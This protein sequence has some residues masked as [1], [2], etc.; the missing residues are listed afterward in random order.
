AGVKASTA[1]VEGIVTLPDY[2]GEYLRILGL[3]IFTSDPFRTFELRTGGASLDLDRWLGRHG[4]L[5]VAEDFTR[6]HN[7]K[8]GAK[9]RVSANAHI[10]DATVVGLMSE[11]NDASHFAAMDIGWAQ[12]L[13]GKQGRLTSIQFLLTKPDEVEE[14]A[15]RIRELVPADISVAPP[16]QRS[17]QVQTMLSAFQLNLTAMSMVSLLVGAFLIYNTISASV[18]RRRTELG[19]LRALGA[20]R[21]EVRSLFL[22]EAMI[23]GAI[24]IALGC[25]G[26]IALARLVIGAVE[27]TISS[28]YLLTSIE[29]SF[30]EGGQIGRAA[31]LGALS[32]LLGA[33]IPAREA[34]R[35]DPIGALRSGEQSEGAGVPTR[36]L[37]WA[38][39]G[40]IALAALACAIALQTGPPLVAF[41]GAF[42]VLAGFGLLAPIA[43]QLTGRAAA[44]WSAAGALWRIAADHLRRS[45]ARNAIT[46]AALAT[47]ISMTI[48][49]TVMIHSFRESVTAWIKR[50]IVAD[51][52]IAPA[53]NEI[54]GL[55]AEVPA[56]PI[57]WLRAHEGVDSVDTFREETI[58]AGSAPALL[59][60]VDGRYRD[61][62]EFQGG[63]ARERMTRVMAGEA[64]AV[65]ESLARKFHVAAG[66]RIS[67]ITPAGPVEFPIA[68][69]YSD[70]T[71]D[72]GAV[73]M[74]RALHDRHW[75][76][77]GPM[78]LAV[79]LDPV[80]DAHAVAD[81][82][83]RAFGT[84]GQ[85][86][87]YTNR[88]IRERILAIFDQ[89]FAVTYVLRTIA[90]MVAALGIFLSVTTL[91][92]ERRR[93][94]AMLR[95][96]GA[97]RAQVQKLFMME[98]GMI[99]VIASV[100][101]LAGGLVLAMVLTWVVNPAFFGWTIH[102]HLP[103][104]VLVTTPAWIVPAAVLSAWLPA[105]QG[106]AE[107]IAESIR[108]E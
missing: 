96:L 15:A 75:P 42:F 40:F 93:E 45:L 86:V 26:G 74:T 34:S 71:R 55:S 30:V 58:T 108:E 19:I 44:C 91:V 90:L 1:L 92:A 46:I 100:L 31:V 89:T 12:E 48:G 61:N 47:A 27:E 16:P 79:Y 9:L 64:V 36:W 76:S 54:I 23:L 85:Y 99:G 10:T 35:V 28:L 63:K 102:L 52:F 80:V 24:G 41:I 17:A 77:A 14:V 81:D 83:R 67:L 21:T 5:A 8:S 107:P 37:S 56:A 66:N 2:P 29:R 60:I 6:R 98:A 106:S 72:Q 7:L 97:T 51:L 84:D 13:L 78:S 70:Y 94:T 50:G 39:V 33:W 20:S 53:S 49:L 104:V 82:F 32:V 57:A 87:I 65:T 105:W 38:A 103:V 68:G 11:M 4:S 43:A 3:D 22:G 73:L 101:G 25:V 88:S 18:A 59:A 69:V 62:L 95:A